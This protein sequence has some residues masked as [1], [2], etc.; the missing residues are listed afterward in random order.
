MCALAH[1][2]RG[3]WAWPMLESP[4]QTQVTAVTQQQRSTCTERLR[5]CQKGGGA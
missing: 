3:L 1:R 2:I 4:Q 5:V